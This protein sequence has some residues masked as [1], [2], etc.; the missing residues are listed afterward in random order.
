MAEET[1]KVVCSFM[2]FIVLGITFLV[3]LIYMEVTAG[4]SNKT[5]ATPTSQ[6][7]EMIKT[8]T[9]EHTT[10]AAMTETTTTT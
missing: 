8:T 10:M 1:S 9:T 5:T 7:V 4:N 6:M 3:V 2:Y